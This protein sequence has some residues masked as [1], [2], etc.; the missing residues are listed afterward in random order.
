MNNYIKTGRLP[1]AA[2]LLSCSMPT[3]LSTSGAAILN[4]LHRINCSYMHVFFAP[5]YEG[6]PF[7]A[8]RKC[9]ATKHVFCTRRLLC[10]PWLAVQVTASLLRTHSPL[11]PLLHGTTKASKYGR[12]NPCRLCFHS[13]P[14]LARHEKDASQ[15]SNIHCR[16]ILHGVQEKHGVGK[17]YQHLGLGIAMEGCIRLCKGVHIV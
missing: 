7:S 8:S 9:E 1:C 4:I 13:L 6:I 3:Q 17:V 15:C 16:D 14:A 10:C 2:G 11:A 5:S 12:H